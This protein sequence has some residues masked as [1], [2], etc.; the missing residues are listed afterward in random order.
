MNVEW[1]GGSQGSPP[2]EYNSALPT[3]RRSLQVGVSLC[4][5]LIIAT[6]IAF[7]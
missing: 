4:G 1:W 6:L 3:T 2:A 7:V 5:Q